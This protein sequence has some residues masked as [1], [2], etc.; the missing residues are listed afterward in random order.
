MRQVPGLGAKEKVF[1]GLKRGQFTS[2][3]AIMEKGEV[4]DCTGIGTRGGPPDGQT[5][6]STLGD[7]FTT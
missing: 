5:T 6:S 7:I 3:F 2:H 1:A 4:R